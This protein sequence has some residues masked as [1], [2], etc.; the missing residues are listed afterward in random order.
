[1]NI[2]WFAP[3]PGCRSGIAVYTS[4]VASELNRRAKVRYWNFWGDEGRQ[5]ADQYQVVDWQGGANWAQ[6][7]NG[8]VPLYHFG[9]NG[10]FHSQMWDLID[11]VPG[12]A[13]IH[14]GTLFHLAIDMFL[15]RKQD[16][17]GL[18]GLMTRLYGTSGTEALRQIL[19]W[20]ADH[21]ALA[22]KFP[23]LEYVLERAT[24]AI[25]HTRT[26]FDRI[27]STNSIPVLYS[28]L[29]LAANVI[30][31]TNRLPPRVRSGNTLR[32]VVFGHLVPNRRLPSILTAIA[33]SAHRNKI[34]LTIGGEIHGRADIEAHIRSLRIQNQVKIAGFLE[35]P[36]LF[37]LLAASDVA[38]NLRNPTMGEASHSQ[39]YLWAFGLPTLVS[40]TGWY[41]EQVEDV[42][43]KCDPL[44]EVSDIKAFFAQAI[45]Q[46]A[47][48]L[49]IGR[50]GR[51][52]VIANHS[53]SSYADDVVGF[54]SKVGKLPHWTLAR[55]FADRASQSL[56][57]LDL[58]VKQIAQSSSIVLAMKDMVG[59]KDEDVDAKG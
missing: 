1:M 35:E 12:I 45:E 31:A 11:A 49:E 17:A 42:T 15:S 23:M 9:N 13:V 38:I 46:P 16:R 14:D 44:N 28:A 55:R 10:T 58:D 22:P 56:S 40:N 21:M 34:K 37:D 53:A 4:D 24:A 20:K 36:A 51:D 32:V 5:L 50:R 7:N 19:A 43:V 3:L 39:L 25:V 41:A 30:E 54:A 29:P 48:I 26:L 8:G 33:E 18:V 6:I 52:W 57:S 2:E 59:M 27:K 47:K